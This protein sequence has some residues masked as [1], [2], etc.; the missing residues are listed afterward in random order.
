M[1]SAQLFYRGKPLKTEG[2]TPMYLVVDHSLHDGASVPRKDTIRVYSNERF[3]VFRFAPGTAA[4]A[5]R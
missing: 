1:L 2:N 4:V 3:E 5:A